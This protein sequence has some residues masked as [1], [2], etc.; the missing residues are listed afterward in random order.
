MSEANEACSDAIEAIINSTPPADENPFRI[1]LCMEDAR[2]EQH[3]RMIAQW[4][5]PFKALEG[6]KIV[7][8]TWEKDLEK[9]YIRQL[10]IA[11]E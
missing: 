8:V 1:K 11:T 9:S 5:A 3:V 10:I 6:K 7:S 4:C 2:T